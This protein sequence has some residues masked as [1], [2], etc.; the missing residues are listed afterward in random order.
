MHI[1]VGKNTFKQKLN[2]DPSTESGRFH[3]GISIQMAIQDDSKQMRRFNRILRAEFENKI[4][5]G[6]ITTL[7]IGTL[8]DRFD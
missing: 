8:G 7:N 2:R 4:H 5:S 3:V 6:D 1:V